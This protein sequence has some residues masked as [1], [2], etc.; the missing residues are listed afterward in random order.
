MT[1]EDLD[2]LSEQEPLPS[3]TGAIS[4]V[5]SEEQEQDNE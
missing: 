1:S 5:T 4:V 2:Q 3:D